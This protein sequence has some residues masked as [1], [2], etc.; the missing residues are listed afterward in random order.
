VSK[1]HL[2][3]FFKE[4]VVVIAATNFPQS[5]DKALVRPGRFDKHVAVPLPDIRGRSQILR[6]Y[7]AEIIS[8]TDVDPTIIARGTPGMSGADLKN[9]VK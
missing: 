7:M 8:S 9:M 1:H 5:L 2:K 4:G 3:I 6:H